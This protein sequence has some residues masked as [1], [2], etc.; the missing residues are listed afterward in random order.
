MSTGSVRLINCVFYAHHGVMQEEHRIG[1]RYEVD[2][3]MDLDFGAAAAEDDL[4]KTVDYERI[5]GMTRDIVTRNRFYLIER[6]AFL[7]AQGVLSEHPIIESVQVTVRKP[8]P[9]VGGPCDRAEA[10]YQARRD[11]GIE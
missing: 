1:G 10:V 9:P 4:G 3:L 8:N 6:L 7:I 5:Y 2:I 11:A